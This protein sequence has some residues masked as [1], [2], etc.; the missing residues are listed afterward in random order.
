MGALPAEA[1][2][3][4]RAGAQSVEGRPGLG[5]GHACAQTAQEGPSDRTHSADGACADA[6]FEM[7]LKAILK[8]FF[9]GEKFCNFFFLVFHSTDQSIDPKV[10]CK[11]ALL[12]RPCDP[13]SAGSL[14]VTGDRLRFGYK[15]LY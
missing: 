11:H 14:L 4:E 12:A 7:M 2:P 15:M 3:P 8:P 9:R 10:S 13:E 5:E 1:S 6:G